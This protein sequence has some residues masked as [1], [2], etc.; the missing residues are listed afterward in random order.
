MRKEQA[1]DLVI[2]GVDDEKN[3]WVHDIL[4]ELESFVFK[5]KGQLGELEGELH[6]PQLG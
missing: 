3:T 4:S 2:A 6:P 5:L 1:V